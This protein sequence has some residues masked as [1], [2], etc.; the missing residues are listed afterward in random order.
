ML[1]QRFQTLRQ[2]HETE[3]AGTARK[4][5]ADPN[6][7]DLTALNEPQRKALI[8]FW[9]A[10]QEE[11]NSTTPSARATASSATRRCIPRPSTGRP[12]SPESSPKAAY[13]MSL[14]WGAGLR[15]SSAGHPQRANP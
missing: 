14:Q 13:R 3:A 6:A 8:R 4:A 12:P 2:Q 10:W 9:E 5:L 15:L 7:Y 1:K 11:E